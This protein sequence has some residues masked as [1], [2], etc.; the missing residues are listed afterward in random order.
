MKDIA[1]QVPGSARVDSLFGQP[2]TGAIPYGSAEG[3]RL[4]DSTAP[5]LGRGTLCSAN[6]DTCGA[7]RVT[8]EQLCAGHLRSERKAQEIVEDE[9]SVALEGETEGAVRLAGDE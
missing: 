9:T 1:F 3:S 8:G 6:G 4:S 5:Y 2:V 7:R